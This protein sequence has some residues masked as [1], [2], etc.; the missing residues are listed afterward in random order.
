MASAGT[1]VASAAATVGGSAV[2]AATTVGTTSVTIAASA[3][4]TAAAAGG[5][6]VDKTGLGKAVDYLDGELDERGVKRAVGSAAG[7]VVNRLDQVTG[8]QLVELLESRLRLPDVAYACIRGHTGTCGTKKGCTAAITD[9]TAVSTTPGR[10][11][12]CDLSFRKAPLY[13]TELRERMPGGAAL[14]P[15]LVIV[16][17][18]TPANK[19]CCRGP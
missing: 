16:R 13:P 5:H 6:V 9:D 4:K 7:A 18:T 1:T 8:R 2:S 12:T 14:A 15:A 10:D 11:R 3:A 17:P 19:N